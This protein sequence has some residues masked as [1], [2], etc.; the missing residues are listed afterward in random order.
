[1]QSF[2]IRASCFFGIWFC[3][4]LASTTAS[5]AVVTVLD[6]A[7]APGTWQASVLGGNAAGS[8]TVGLS[9][10]TGAGV[11]GN[12]QTVTINGPGSFTFDCGVFKTNYAWNPA[13]DGLLTGIDW[14]TW[15]KTTGPSEFAGWRLAA[16]QG[17]T[18]FLANSTFFE[19]QLFSPNWQRRTGA[20]DPATAF[21]ATWGPPA[22]LNLG[23][24]GSLITFGFVV[25]RGDLASGTRYW[26]HSFFKLD[27][28]HEPVP[29]PGAIAVALLGLGAGGTC[30]RRRR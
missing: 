3:A 2:N 11:T 16:K 15:H 5:A 23:P 20:V 25:T 12:A 18:T 13:T 21:N 27:L 14:E 30:R 8:T 6:T 10:Q 9:T 17:N 29:A 7:F 26:R 19:P 28:T 1:M 4:S 24:S 22:T